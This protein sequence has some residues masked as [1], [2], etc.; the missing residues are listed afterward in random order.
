MLLR[1]TA[2]ADQRAPEDK[3]WLPCDGYDC[4]DLVVS[5]WISAGPKDS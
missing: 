3:S 4:L 2:S 1:A 5:G